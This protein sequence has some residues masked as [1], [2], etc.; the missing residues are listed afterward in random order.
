MFLDRRYRQIHFGGNFRNR[1]LVNSSQHEYTAALRRH[2]ID[3]AF[4]LAKLVTRRYRRLGA[5][6]GFIFTGI[7]PAVEGDKR[8]APGL[9][10]QHVARDTE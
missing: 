4:D 9:I 6:V 1:A 3:C 2:S 10:D 8:T 5:S 7:V